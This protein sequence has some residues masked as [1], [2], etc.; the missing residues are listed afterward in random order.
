MRTDKIGNE[1]LE[2]RAVVY[3]RQSSPEQVRQNL[4]SQRLQYELV[5]TA[6][7]LGWQEVEV[8]DE[9]MA[10]SASTSEGRTGFQQLAALICLNEVGAVFCFDASR[11]ARNNRDWYYLLDVCGLMKTLLIDINQVFDPRLTDD[12]MLLGL[13]GQISEYELSML[14]Q[15]SREA[16]KSKARRGE[17]FTRVPVGYIRVGKDR[18]EKD[19][20]LRV[21]EAIAQIF[22]KFKEMGSVRQVALWFRHEGIAVPCERFND[23]G[24]ALEWRIPGYGTL[25]KILT[26][27]FYAGVYF[28]GRTTAEI[29]GVNGRPQKHR[30]LVHDPEEWEVC[31]YHHHEGYITW[32][33]HEWILSVLDNNLMRSGSQAQGAAR[34]GESLLAGLLRCRRCG[35]R[36]KVGYSSRGTYRYSCQGTIAEQECIAFG[37]ITVDRA[38]ANE[39]LRVVEPTALEAAMELAREGDRSLDDRQKALALE[40]QQIEYEARRAQKQYDAVDPENRL[41][42]VELE[43]RW[44]EALTKGARLKAELERLHEKYETETK[45]S[46]DEILALATDFPALWHDPDTDQVLK[47]R[48]IRTLIEEIVV[49]VDEDTSQI[50]AVIRWSGGTH[51][52]LE[53]KKYRVGEHR[54]S[55]DRETVDLVRDL[56]K[57]TDDANI[58]RI[59]NRMGVATGKGNTWTSARVRSLRNN[60]A[61]QVYNPIR[62]EI[63]GWLTLEQ[64]AEVL[65]ISPMS[66]RRLINEG[67]IEGKQV[68]AYAPWVITKACLDTPTVRHA[69]Q[70]IQQGRRH[71]PL[72]ELENQA[73]LI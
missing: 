36:L 59:L 44:N 15:R 52:Q 33:E 49:D 72:P 17:I 63:E 6:R 29:I 23:E 5:Q 54:Y 21:Q 1:H 2:R 45:W 14:R 22:R 61:I 51:T 43:R 38:I 67:I 58:A 37:G 46:R 70:R 55:T 56:A 39:V 60:R 53:F 40:L 32:E 3:V 41:V 34:N 9:D 19:P 16:I 8:I 48:L 12:R 24:R 73:K 65:G 71:A 30:Y 28:F 7:K 26:N 25:H 64:T 13:K 18:C 42:A 62:Q 4:E 50:R 66:V 35:R 69:V 10:K 11:L 68:I 31:L 27:P 47:K 57:V 20:N